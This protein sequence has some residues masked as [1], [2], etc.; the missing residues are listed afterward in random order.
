[1]LS[2]RT[3][4]HL[5]RA[6]LASST[7]CVGC[8]A[9]IHIP[10][11]PSPIAKCSRCLQ[12]QESTEEGEV[13]S[14][15]KEADKF[16]TTLSTLCRELEKGFEL[17]ACTDGVTITIDYTDI[18]VLRNC[19]RCR[20]I[21]SSDWPDRHVPVIINDVDNKYQGVSPLWYIPR[22]R[23]YQSGDVIFDGIQS[24]KASRF[25]QDSYNRMYEVYGQRRNARDCRYYSL[26]SGS[27]NTILVQVKS[28]VE[29]FDH[30]RGVQRREY[31]RSLASA[32]VRE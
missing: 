6:H 13:H 23:R 25:S 22:N 5:V 10:L 32:R 28:P 26:L 24:I 16:R 29:M 17:K 14:N 31:L 8:G 21:E 19:L 3:W 7:R 12:A 11:S 20:G 27:W 18:D 15:P 1:M 9:H 30:L 2:S 4:Y